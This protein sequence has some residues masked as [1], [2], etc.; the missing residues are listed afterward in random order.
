MAATIPPTM[1]SWVVTK[2]G[3]PSA[4]LALDASA[5]VPAAQGS[6]VLVKVSHASLNPADL[7][8]MLRIPTILPFRRRPTPGLD[9]C[10]TVVALGPS[11]PASSPVKLEVGDVVCGAVPASKVALGTGTLAEYVS[12][13][14]DS[15]ALKPESLPASV[16]AGLGI[17]G[18]TAALVMAEAKIEPGHR[19]LVNG[20][21]GGVGTMLCQIVTA[22]GGIVTAVC[23][24]SNAKLVK[25]L[26]ASEVIDY[27]ANSPVFEHLEAEYSQKPFDIII[28]CVGNQFLYDMCAAYLKPTGTFIN[29]VGGDTEGVVPWVK[30]TIWPKFLGGTPRR[31]RILALL[32]NG[33]LQREVVQWVDDGHL[34]EVV[35]DSEVSVDEVVEAYEKLASKRAKGKIIVRID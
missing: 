28:D 9:F 15:V 10:G 22:R 19:V 29:I 27:M 11:I 20:A 23:S 26:G 5:P 24:D 25:R 18:Q 34:P 4:A 7:Q 13:P 35:I 1:R 2:N 17:A 30:G 31:Y 32:P 14:A 8:H 3:A 33:N 6:T 12:V 21:S 16:C